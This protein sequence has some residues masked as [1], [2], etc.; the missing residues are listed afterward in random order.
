MLRVV[1]R[2]DRGETMNAGVLLYCRRLDYLG[3]RVWLDED[4]LRALD[5][6]ADPAA[7]GGRCRPRPTSAAGRPTRDRR[8]GRT[9]AGGSAG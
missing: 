2:V 4:R 1:P 6:A 8:P 3:S 7:V 5:P 9:W